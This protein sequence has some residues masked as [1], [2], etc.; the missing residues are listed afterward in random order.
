MYVKITGPD[1]ARGGYTRRVGQ[2][3]G[4]VTCDPVFSPGDDVEMELMVNPRHSAGVKVKADIVSV[5]TDTDSNQG[6][7]LRWRVASSSK[8]PSILGRFL[9]R[10]LGIEEPSVVDDGT[11]AYRFRHVFPDSGAAGLVSALQAMKSRPMGQASRRTVM[12]TDPEMGPAKLQDIIGPVGEPVVA[13]PPTLNVEE[14]PSNDTI[15]DLQDDIVEDELVFEETPVPYEVDEPPKEAVRP[16]KAVAKTSPKLP[17][18]RPEKRFGTL[19]DERRMRPRIA[20]SVPVSFFVNSRGTV[21]RAHNISRSGL[22]IES[23]ESPPKVGSRVNV[24]FPVR[25]A[26]VNHVVLLTCEVI[27]HRAPREKPGS[28]HGFAVCYLVV[29]ELGR[30]GVFSHFINQHV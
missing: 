13:R 23:K 25:H 14:E 22:Y 18:S 16:P 10:V 11:D 26:G 21:A 30:T 6:I 2:H 1:L 24:R 4:F 8:S 20:A 9:S 7:E 29:D 15:P 28:R 12:R 3:G 27:R 5:R 17:P 19:T